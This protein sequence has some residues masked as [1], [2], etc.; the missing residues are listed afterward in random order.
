MIRRCSVDQE[1]LGTI[2]PIKNKSVTHGYCRKHELMLLV[3]NDLAT[4]KEI[5]EFCGFMMR[6]MK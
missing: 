5:K 4:K 6:A 1:Y 2:A 3:N